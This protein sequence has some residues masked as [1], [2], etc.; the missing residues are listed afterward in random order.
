[1]GL[2]AYWRW[3]FF[4]FERESFVVVSLLV[5]PEVFDHGVARLLA[6]AGAPGAQ[7]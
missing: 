6:R 7:S 1:M 5:E 3:Y 4:D 2:T